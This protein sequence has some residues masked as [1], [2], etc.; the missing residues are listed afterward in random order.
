VTL[1]PEPFSLGKCPAAHRVG[2]HNRRR[3]ILAA[4][5]VAGLLT[6]GCGS[7]S[8][9]DAKPAATSSPDATSDQILP[10]TTTIVAGSEAAGG[11]CE[12]VS[13]EVVA[14]VLGVSI[15]RREPHGEPGGP[16]VTCIK[17]PSGSTTW[18]TPP[19]SA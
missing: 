13:D 6:A 18:Q 1:A 8:R 2:Y 17:A 11:A 14:E 7:E 4:T 3:F 15:T 16:T 12:I 5:L 10:S 19:S 9:S